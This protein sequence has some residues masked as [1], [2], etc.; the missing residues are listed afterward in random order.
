MI[1]KATQFKSQS[2]ITSWSR[3]NMTWKY[4]VVWS[5]LIWSTTDA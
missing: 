4:Q 2:K 5:L 1:E 3:K